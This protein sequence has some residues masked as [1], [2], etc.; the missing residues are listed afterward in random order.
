MRKHNRQVHDVAF[1]KKFSDDYVEKRFLNLM[2]NCE[3]ELV[4]INK[5]FNNFL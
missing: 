2:E 5:T 1:L 4:E 3:R